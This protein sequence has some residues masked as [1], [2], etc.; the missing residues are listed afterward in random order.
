MRLKTN[1]QTPRAFSR[2]MVSTM[3]GEVIATVSI[4][5]L[6]AAMKLLKNRLCKLQ[7]K[8]PLLLRWI[9]GHIFLRVQIVHCRLQIVMLLI[10][11][12]LPF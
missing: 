6:C 11:Y 3:E 1:D 10:L 5:L 4:I 7:K 8:I 2:Q 12:F 9:S